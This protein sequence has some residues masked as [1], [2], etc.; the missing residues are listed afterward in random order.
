MGI[1]NT[2]TSYSFGQ[3]GSMFIDVTVSDIKP[4]IGKVFVAITVIEDC[5]F[6]NSGG[7]IADI[8]NEDRGLQYVGTDK[9]AHSASPRTTALGIGG[10]KIQDDTTFQA[11]LTIYGRWTT[12]DLTSG[13]I[14]AYIGD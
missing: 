1:N 7:L 12:V 4:P 14:I 10:K 8:E 5:T 13:K 3:L 2:Q 9:E 11:G 6:D